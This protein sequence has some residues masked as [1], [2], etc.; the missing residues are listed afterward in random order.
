VNSNEDIRGAVPIEGGMRGWETAPMIG[1]TEELKQRFLRAIDVWLDPRCDNAADDSVDRW[2]GPEC[3]FLAYPHENG[4]ELD[5]D[6]HAKLKKLYCHD[7]WK[8]AHAIYSSL[9]SYFPKEDLSHVV[10][11]AVAFHA[12]WERNLLE[13]QDQLASGSYRPGTYRH[14]FVYEP[15][16]RK[17]IAAPFRD[18]IVHHAVVNVLEPIYERRFIPDS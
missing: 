10:N 5:E 8:S 9:L 6:D 18:R 16:R 3:A 15:K 12:H 11:L 7:H 2:L 4:C 13:L 1:R 17:I 14:F